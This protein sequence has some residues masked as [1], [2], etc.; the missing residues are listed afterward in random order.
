M[1]AFQTLRDYHAQAPK[2]TKSIFSQIL[3]VLFFGIIIICLYK[4]AYIPFRK[5]SLRKEIANLQ[6]DLAIS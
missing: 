5:S 3:T 4:F 1:Q 6:A 2:K